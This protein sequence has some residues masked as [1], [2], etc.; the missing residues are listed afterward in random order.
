MLYPQKTVHNSEHGNGNAETTDY[1]QA[2]RNAIAG[3]ALFRTRE[4]NNNIYYCHRHII[5]NE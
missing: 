3:I 4:L 1:T 2:M 5:H